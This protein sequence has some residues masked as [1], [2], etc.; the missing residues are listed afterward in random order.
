MVGTN[1]RIVTPWSFIFIQKF[2]EK[3]TKAKKKSNPALYLYISILFLLPSFF[4]K[5]T[6]TIIQLKI[7]ATIFSV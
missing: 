2:N 6:P 4:L 7:F 5:K 3:P 1:R